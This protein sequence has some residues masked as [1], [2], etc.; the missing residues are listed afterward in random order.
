MQFGMNEESVLEGKTDRR[1]LEQGESHAQSDQFPPA[2]KPAHLG[3]PVDCPRQAVSSA[4][5]ANLMWDS[6]LRL[7]DHDQTK[8]RH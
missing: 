6:I 5:A 1:E 8:G 7:Q 2:H 3:R 4:L